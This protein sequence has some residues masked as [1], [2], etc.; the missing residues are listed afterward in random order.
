MEEEEIG[1]DN[2]NNN[3]NTQIAPRHCTEHTMMMEEKMSLIKCENACN[4]YHTIIIIGFAV[5]GNSNSNNNNII[6]NNKYGIGGSLNIGNINSKAPHS[7]LDYPPLSITKL[8]DLA[9]DSPHSVQCTRS[10]HWFA[11]QAARHA[12]NDDDE[13]EDDDDNGDDDDDDEEEAKECA[14]VRHAQYEYAY[15]SIQIQYSICQFMCIVKWDQ[16]QNNKNNNRNTNRGNDNSGV[17][18]NNME[19]FF[20]CFWFSIQTPFGHKQRTKNPMDLDSFLVMLAKINQQQQHHN[21]EMPTPNQQAT[22]KNNTKTKTLKK[23]RICC[24]LSQADE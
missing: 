5:I 7:S 13:D 19:S 4:I 23:C 3:K 11:F 22:T 17:E 12:G 15:M 14:W 2:K 10:K 6:I 8:P 24:S 9:L 16:K 21:P 20:F 1:S 18:D